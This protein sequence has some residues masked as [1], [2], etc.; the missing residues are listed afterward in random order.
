[1]QVTIQIPEGA[2][3]PVMLTAQ[4]Q[5]LTVAQLV[6]IEV[7]NRTCPPDERDE[8]VRQARKENATHVET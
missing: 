7:I 6:A 4:A 2:V 3:R 5:G 1:M 8:L